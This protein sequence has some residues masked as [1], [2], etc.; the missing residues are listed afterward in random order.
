MTEPKK[1][2]FHALEERIHTMH[3]EAEKPTERKAGPEAEQPARDEGKEK[4]PAPRQ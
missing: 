3:E 2:G 1:R 4:A